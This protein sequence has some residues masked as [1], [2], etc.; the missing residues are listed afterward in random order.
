VKVEDSAQFDFVLICLGETC[1]NLDK[2]LC[3]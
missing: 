1:S 2:N 3:V